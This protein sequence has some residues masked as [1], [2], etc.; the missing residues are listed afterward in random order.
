MDIKDFLPKQSSF[1]K[2]I[3]EVIAYMIMIDKKHLGPNIWPKIPN[4]GIGIK[5]IILTIWY[6]KAMK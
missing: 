4:Q 1:Y 5:D 3:W 2:F 6:K